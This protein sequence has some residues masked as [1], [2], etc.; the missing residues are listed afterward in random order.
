MPVML[1]C[2]SS[3]S[4]VF[5]SPTPT[6]DSAAGVGRAAVTLRSCWRVPAA[7]T[8]IDRAVLCVLVRMAEAT[9]RRKRTLVAA[10]HVNEAR[11]DANVARKPWLA[12]MGRAELRET[13]HL[14]LDLSIDNAGN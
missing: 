5:S 4:W 10:T 2:S 8:S 7:V 11:R 3:S 6:G 12:R 1:D 9:G 13:L 14:N